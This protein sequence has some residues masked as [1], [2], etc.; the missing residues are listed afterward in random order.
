MENTQNPQQAYAMPRIGDTAPDFEALTT[1]GKIKFSDYAPGKWVV[2]FSHPADFTPV[3][4]TEMSGFAQRKGEFDALN[5]E[6]IGLSIDSIHAHLGW[7]QNV[8]ENTGIYFDFPIIADL[9]M[10]V[11]KLYGMLQPNESETAAVRAVFFIDP[12]KKIRL[13]MYYPLNVGRNMDEILRALDALQ[14]SDKHRVAMPLDWKRGEKVIVPPPKSLDELNARL[15]D[16]TLE[17]VDWYLAK[18]ELQN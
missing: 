9:D 3:C 12:D 1:K 8:R 11:A 17:K 10:K 16:Q 7:V 14:V 4:T 6:L 15:A 2:M 13:I 18:K 5:T